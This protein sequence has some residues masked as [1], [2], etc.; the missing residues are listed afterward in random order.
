MSEIF[1]VRKNRSN[2][3]TKEPESPIK[4][5]PKDLLKRAVEIMEWLDS[6]KPLYDELD[7]TVMALKAEKFKSSEVTYNGAKVVMALVDNFAEKNTAFKACGVKR[8]ELKV[9]KGGPK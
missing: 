1:K 3:T 4:G 7:R 5:L 9:Q 2:K 6:V 8:F